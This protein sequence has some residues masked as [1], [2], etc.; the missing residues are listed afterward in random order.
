[1]DEKLKK[2][3]DNVCNELGLTMTTAITMLAKQMTRER[4][5]PFEVTLDP[6][7]SR[8]NM[9]ALRGS[10]AQM[11]EGK[12]VMKTLDELEAMAHE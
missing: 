12:T 9:D 2:E 1:M 5:I 6:F 11:Q 7:Y 3:F 4:R 10:I 8:S